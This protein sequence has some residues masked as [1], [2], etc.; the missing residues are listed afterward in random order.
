MDGT[1]PQSSALIIDLDEAF[2]EILAGKV[3]DGGLPTYLS[4]ASRHSQAGDTLSPN[5]FGNSVICHI[6]AYKAEPDNDWK[7]S[8]DF[9]TLSENAVGRLDNILQ[10]RLR[11]EGVEELQAPPLER[12]FYF[13]RPIDTVQDNPI[14]KEES[15]MFRIYHATKIGLKRVFGGSTSNDKALSAENCRRRKREIIF[16][17]LIAACAIVSGAW[18]LLPLSPHNLSP[19]R[20]GIPDTLQVKLSFNLWL[21]IHRFIYTV[22]GMASCLLIFLVGLRI[23]VPSGI[24]LACLTGACA[25]DLVACYFL[26]SWMVLDGTEKKTILLVYYQVILSI[27]GMM[28]AFVGSVAF[29]AYALIRQRR[30]QKTV[31]PM[32]V[33]G[34]NQGE[35]TFTFKE[36]VGCWML[37]AWLLF[38]Y[39][40]CQC[41]KYFFDEANVLNGSRLLNTIMSVFFSFG[42]TLFQGLGIIIC[43]KMFRNGFINTSLWAVLTSEMF[44]FSYFRV[45][46][47]HI[48]DMSDM[49]VVALARYIVDDLIRFVLAMSTLCYY[50]L[51][52]FRL[53]KNT[54]R[55]YR[56]E[57]L[58]KVEIHLLV[59]IAS[60][61][62]YAANLLI[63][64]YS[65]NSKFFTLNSKAGITT[66]LWFH[67]IM[68][69]VEIVRWIAMRYFCSYACEARPNLGQLLEREN[70]V[71]LLLLI[72]TTIHVSQDPYFAL[73]NKALGFE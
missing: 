6:N 57:L 58:W 32:D 56:R 66:L 73:L 13:W 46:F 36:V 45:L 53:T 16:H 70:A 44:Y 41:F 22:I 50:F 68:V 14:F 2:E 25:I 72:M 61:G 47:T 39:G 7:G 37:L 67:L 60:I 43:K 49:L 19:S 27:T 64:E 18:L 33:A 12:Q 10:V 26:R 4:L 51:V 38:L 29:T 42:V 20:A 52:Y 62:N 3:K 30:F 17:V 65:W 55:A 34:D 1:Q 35:Y 21:F 63:V 23:N 11:K 5:S 8:Q 9:Q 59:G 48:S 54:L 31:V 69:L 28:S 40:G 15:V 24:F 71:A